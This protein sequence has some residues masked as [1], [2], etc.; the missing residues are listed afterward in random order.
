MVPN[1]PEAPAARWAPWL[2]LVLPGGGLVLLGSPW[3]GWLVGVVCAACA[4]L[5]VVATLLLPDEFPPAVRNLVLGLAGGC[6]VGAQVRLRQTRR[7]QRARAERAWRRAV[8][9]ETQRW[10][11][12]GEAERA[13][14][15]IAPLAERA[16]EDVLV[17]Y[18]LAQ[19]LTAAGRVGAARA[20]WRRVRALDR[21]GLYRA[22]VLENERR[23]GPE[24]LL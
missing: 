7:A 18:R 16:G 15:A 22:Q 11:S 3:A 19:A 2:N 23:L 21:H 13:L 20:A 1:L 6:Y 17:A 9:A 14:A 24:A 5:A 4:N 8:L 12:H 10:L